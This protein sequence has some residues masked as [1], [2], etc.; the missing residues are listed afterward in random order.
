MVGAAQRCEARA[1]L[2]DY[3]GIASNLFVAVDVWFRGPASA[4]VKCSD[5]SPY[6]GLG[7][8]ILV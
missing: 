1:G 5:D 2:L 4:T 7:L 3:Y 8:H 6:F